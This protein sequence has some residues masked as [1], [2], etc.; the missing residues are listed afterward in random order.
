VGGHFNTQQREIYQIVAKILRQA[1][2]LV[3][4]GIAYRDV[5]LTACRILVEEL[6]TLGLMRGDI[7][8][9]VAEGAYALFMPHGLGHQLGLDVHDMEDLGED[10]VGY[11]DHYH[12]S[13]QFGLSGLRLGRK[14]EEGFVV[15]VEPGIYFIPD[16]IL[17]W[18]NE[19]RHA[20]FINYDKLDRYHHFGGIRLEDDVLVMKSG[21]RLLGRP[22][23]LLELD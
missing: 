4:P 5:H 10:Y 20:N 17:Q 6:Q 3:Q 16:L 12:R 2:R 22:V 11:D 7:D 21:Q 8:Q 23:P 13:S 19:G 9:A 15:T 18:Q 14:L 1:T